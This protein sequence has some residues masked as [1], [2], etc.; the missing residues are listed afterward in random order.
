MGL[1]HFTQ[2]KRLCKTL[3]EE[4]AFIKSSSTKAYSNLAASD[5]YSERIEG[6]YVEEEEDAIAVLEQD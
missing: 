4:F 6:S 3:V 2:T 1:V 5:D